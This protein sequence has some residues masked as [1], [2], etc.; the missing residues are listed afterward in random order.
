MDDTL[1]LDQ[2]LHTNIPYT[3]V[4]PDVDPGVHFSSL[5]DLINEVQTRLTKKFDKLDESFH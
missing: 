4:P 1:A 3:E 2:S 5:N